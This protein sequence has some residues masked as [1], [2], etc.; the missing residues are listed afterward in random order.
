MRALP[1][2]VATVLL[3]LTAGCGGA[4]EVKSGALEKQ[5]STQLTKSVG[6][7]PDSVDCPKGLKAEKGATTRC[8]LTAGSSTYGVTVRTT[9]VDGDKVAFAIKVD[10]KP[11][12]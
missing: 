8:S 9:K 2:V 7:K 10:D 12:S 1:V 11:K 4:K 5:V 3:G 6:Q